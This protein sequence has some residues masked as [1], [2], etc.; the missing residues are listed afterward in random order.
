MPGG[1]H[2]VRL[3]PR[4]APHRFHP[5]DGPGVR[6]V[7]R[8]ED[9]PAAVVEALEGGIDPAVLGARDGMGRNEKGGN[10]PERGAGGA[11]H[12][13]LDAPR[14]GERNLR[15]EPREKRPEDLLHRPH[16][17]AD[18]D[19][20]RPAGGLG[21]IEGPAV[22]DPELARAAKVLLAPARPHHLADRAGAPQGAGEGAADET[23]PDDAEAFDHPGGPGPR[24]DSITRSERIPGVA[25]TCAS[26]SGSMG[27]STSTR[28]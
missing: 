8:G 5:I 18:D 22:H 10:A 23:D 9:D 15:V 24:P 17:G 12:G 7:P 27:R 16:R 2:P 28:V 3:R 19:H 13:L 20:V 25:A 26:T 4:R 6:R 11:E 14:V 1:V 21:D